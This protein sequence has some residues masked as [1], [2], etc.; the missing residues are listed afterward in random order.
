MT[1]TMEDLT[2]EWPPHVGRYEAR[3]FG[4]TLI[5]AVAA[6]MSFLVIIALSSQLVTAVVVAA[7]V[8]LCVRRLERLGGV[9]LPVYLFY[10]L[11]AATSRET[12]E[13]PLITTY[14]HDG[15]VEIENWD[16]TTVAVIE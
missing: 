9:S 2:Y 7:I 8:L 14:G 6:V 11:R 3:F 12:L 13:L 1:T 5:E 4:F 10:R 16:G 15:V